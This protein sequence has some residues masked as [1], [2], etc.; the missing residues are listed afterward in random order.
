[1]S[2][3]VLFQTEEHATPDRGVE[4]AT[5]NIDGIDYQRMKIDVGGDGK[6]GGSASIDNPLPV[7]D[8]MMFSLLEEI[9]TTLKKIET[10]LSYATDTE[11]KDQDV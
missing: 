5:D 7:K 3:N 1:M 8:L 9:L 2:D 10:H 11:L 4:V 6:V